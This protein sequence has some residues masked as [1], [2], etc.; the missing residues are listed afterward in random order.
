MIAALTEEVTVDVVGSV[1]LSEVLVSEVAVLIEAMEADVVGAD[2]VAVEAAEAVDTEK[3]EE[4][5]GG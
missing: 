2:D 4:V 1:K 3:L 5:T